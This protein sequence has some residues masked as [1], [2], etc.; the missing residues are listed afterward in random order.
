MI[1]MMIIKFYDNYWKNSFSH[2]YNQI[3]TKSRRFI[4]IVNLIP[5]KASG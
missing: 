3:N 4:R 2:R 1:N 5:V